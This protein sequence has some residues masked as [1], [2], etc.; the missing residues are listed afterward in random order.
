MGAASL[1]V[2]VVTACIGILVS[3]AMFRAG[4]EALR[5]LFFL[6]DGSWRRFG[7]PA[8]L[9]AMIALSLIGLVVTPHVAA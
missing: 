5:T 2:V 4:P 3:L 8:W 1:L 7:W 9:A 6:P